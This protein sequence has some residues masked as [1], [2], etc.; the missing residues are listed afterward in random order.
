MMHMT[1]KI[2]HE[3]IWYILVSK[4][5]LEPQQYRVLVRFGLTKLKITYIIFSLYN[6]RKSFVLMVHAAETEDEAGKLRNFG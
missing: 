1:S 5:A 3:S 6:F 2:Q 4:E